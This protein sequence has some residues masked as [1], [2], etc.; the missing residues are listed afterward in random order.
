[1]K[2]RLIVVALAVLGASLFVQPAKAQRGVPYGSGRGRGSF[3]RARRAGRF[4]PGFYPYLFP[5]YDDYGPEPGLVEAPAPQTIIVQS[6]QPVATATVPTPAKPSEPLVIEL[7]GDHWVRLTNSGESQVGGPY[8]AVPQSEQGAGPRS[9][10]NTRR[11]ETAEAENELPPAVLVFRDGHKEQVRK[12]MVMGTTIYTNSD[13]WTSGSWT[14]KI[15]IAELDVPATL[16]LNQEQG[17]KFSL[18]SGPNEIMVR[19]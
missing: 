4:F 12:Y 16:K 17:A 1:M 15:Q 19:P 10:S 6:A 11:A 3:A 2:K 18:P 7:D 9:T 13:Y 14:R 5:D 8:G